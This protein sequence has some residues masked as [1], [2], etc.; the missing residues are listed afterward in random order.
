MKIRNLRELL[1]KG[2]LESRTAILDIAE[3][4]LQDLDGFQVLGDLLSVDGNKL[5]VNSREWDL[6]RKRGLWV[7]GAG[8][9]CNA[10]AMAVEKRLGDR[11]RGGLVIV[12]QIEPQDQLR[13]IELVVGGHP[14]PNQESL[15]ASRRIL[16]MIEKA[17]PE[18]LFICLI[19]GG[20]SALMACPVRGIT[21]EDEMEATNLLLKSSARILEI[22]A[23]RRHISE[24]NGGRLAQKIE[25]RGAELIC[26]IID[27]VVAR[28]PK[29]DGGPAHKFYGTPI[30]PDLSTLQDARNVLKKYDLG[31]SVPA[32]IVEYLKSNDPVRETPKVLGPRTHHFVIQKPKD[33]CEAARRNA[34]RKGLPGV[35]LTTFLEGESREAGTFLA[36]IAKE[37]ALNRRPVGAPC[38]L[39]AGGETTTRVEKG[40]GLGGP[41]QELALGF[42]LEIT[43]LKGCCIAAIDT[44]GSDGP[45]DFAGGVADSQTVARAQKEGLEV[46]ESLKA[47]DSSA[48]LRALE[49]AVITGNTGTNVC[50]LNMVYVPANGD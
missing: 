5:R 49:D 42:S 29:G 9:A 21:L 11:I 38:V 4:T 14:L 32:S 18:D 23:I 1:S 50:D 27:D 36:G 19:S 2:D 44:D 3:K 15:R 30:G 12:K 13:H 43:D 7:I 25:A 33:A 48:V 41:S 40:T 35:I 45:T 26:F 39:I 46:Y 10:M 47:H 24:T 8:K 6:G 16:K 37:I 34:E 28:V 31:S 22:N 17:T 20:S